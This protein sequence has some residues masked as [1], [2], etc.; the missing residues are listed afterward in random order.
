MIKQSPLDEDFRRHTFELLSSA[1]KNI[2]I[3][4]GEVGSF[5][6]FDLR[7]VAKKAHE[8]GVR[9]RVYANQPS[10]GIINK[11]LTYGV[12]LYLGEKKVRDHYLVVDGNSWIRS[13]E[14]PPDQIG[15]RKGYVYK[16]DPKG[17]SRIIKLFNELI[18]KAKKIEEPKWDEDPLWLMLQNP[19]DWGVET[20]SSKFDEEFPR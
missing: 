18:T 6:F 12:E 10:I 11:L 14:H 20:D 19:L 15:L 13:E 16:N 9:I 1:K 8:R 2:L 3:I 17:A 5:K 4:A 7:M